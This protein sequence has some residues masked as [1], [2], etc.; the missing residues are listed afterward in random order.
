[1]HSRKS[2]ANFPLYTLWVRSS[3][4]KL[5]QFSSTHLC[6]PHLRIW[7][8]CL[9]SQGRWE[10]FRIWKNKDASINGLLASTF[11]SA[12]FTP[13]YILFMHTH[14]CILFLSPF[15]ERVI[16][17]YALNSARVPY[18]LRLGYYTPVKDKRV[19]ST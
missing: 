14:T 19:L 16:D 12:H 11:C 4:L 6:P 10:L 18:T 17:H 1:M 5:P 7:I 9:E 15:E 8:L 2:F 3:I 13:T